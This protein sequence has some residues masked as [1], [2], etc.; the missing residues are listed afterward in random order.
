MG[1]VTS[2]VAWSTMERVKRLPGGER[3][4]NLLLW[5]LI[6]GPLLLPADSVSQG[7]PS[8]L[9]LPWVKIAAVPLLGLAVYLARR[10]PLLAVLAPAV[11]GLAATPE[12]LSGNLAMAQVVLA[13]LLGRRTSGRRSAGLCFVLVCLAGVLLLLVTPGATVADGLT[14]AGNVLLVLTL[15]W[16]VGHC[17]RQRAELAHTG[18]RLAEWL[19]RE[20]RVASDRARLRE[21]S[22]IAQDMHD[23][24]GHELSLIALRAGALQVAEDVGPNGRQAAGELRRAAAAATQRLRDVIGVLRDDD[25]GTPLRPAGE[26]VAA[27]VERAA[28]AGAPVTL[29]D[30][31][32]SVDGGVRRTLPPMTDRAIYRVVQEALTNATKHAPGAAIT[33]RLRRSGTQAWVT[34]INEAPAAGPRRAPA[35]HPGVPGHG[36]VGLDERVRQAGGTARARPF[37]GGFVVTARLPLRP[38][39]PATPPG[40]CGV[41][42]RKFA[43]ARRRARR[44][45]I[46]AAWTPIA[47]TVVLLA[48]TFGYYRYAAPPSVLDEGVYERLRIGDSRSSVERWLPAHQ[49]AGGGRGGHLPADP[50]GSDGCLFYS[51]SLDLPSPRYRLCFTGGRLSHKDRVDLDG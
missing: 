30:R 2:G 34:V 43:V 33:V 11:L 44:R 18:W 45:M 1:V 47:A 19:E 22:R 3:T 16:L 14:L 7:Q 10:C 49:A 40:D 8:G 27:L 25:A 51:A 28:A 37:R 15:P 31:L 39:A 13:Y 17:L 21:R 41:A 23:S 6:T 12:L 24:L 32:G 50:S 46:D 29:D 9:P 36:L 20:Q 48:L 38:G 26:T 42:W 4:A 5:L 35:A